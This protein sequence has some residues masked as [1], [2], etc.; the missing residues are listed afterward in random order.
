VTVLAGRYELT[1]E[2]GS[3][4][5]GRVVVAHDRLLGR[6][7]AIKLLSP[8]AEEVARERFVREARSAARLHH[9]NVVSVFDTGEEDGQPYLVMELVRGRSLADVL[10]DDGPMAVDDAV[11]V[12]L[13]VLDGLEAAHRSGMIHRD[14]KP[15]NVLLPDEGGVKLSDFGIAKAIDES[16]VELTAVGS[17][18]GTPTY[19][20]P[21][22]VGGAPPSAASDVYSV[23]CLLYAQLAGKPPFHEGEPLTVAY[24]HRN[25][26]VPP[27]TDARP[28][29][30]P[31]VVTVV[32]RALEKDPAVRYSSAGA[33]RTALLDGPEAVPLAGDATVAMAGVAPT[34]RTQVMGNSDEE[35][36]RAIGAGAAAPAAAPPRTPAPAPQR[37]RR[38]W[39]PAL[40]VVALLAAAFILWPL[41]SGA[42]G[43]GDLIEDEPDEVEEIEDEPTEEPTDEPPVD[44]S[45]E[46]PP[47]TPPEEPDDEPPA[48]E[49]DEPEEEEEPPVEIEDPLE[50]E[51]E[52]EPPPEEEEDDSA[53]GA[54]GDTEDTDDGSASGDT[55]ETDDTDA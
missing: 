21:E 55:D 35:P 1:E 47:Q 44:E 8:Q 31:E 19:L 27:I 24:A 34:D 14:V 10:Y 45:P 15:A 20:A 22:L 12:T 38:W 11:A 49:P 52:E 51:E 48:E 42:P 25:E 7:V 53:A 23:G 33:M 18:M 6:D 26:P 54:D 28:D 9:P 37:G 43:D 2:L 41:L 3:G 46:T 40:I 13:G 4:G 50:E 30:P 29:L 36:T 32:E 39:I 17:L 5:M 16:D